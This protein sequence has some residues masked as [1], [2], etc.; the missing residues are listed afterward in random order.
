MTS[1]VGTSST[2]TRKSTLTTCWITGMTRIRPGPLTLSKRPSVKMTPRSYSRRI[3]MV[4]NSR[5]S[6]NTSP[7][8]KKVT[9]RHS[10][11]FSFK[12]AGRP[13]GQKQPFGLQYFNGLAGGNGLVRPGA[14]I[15]ALDINPPFSVCKVINRFREPAVQ[16][17]TAGVN[18][19]SPC[20]CGQIDNG[21]KYQRRGQAHGRNQPGVDAHA[22]HI[23]VNQYDG[24]D[25][26]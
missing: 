23:A 9:F 1:W 20:S 15:L 7:N 6:K 26:H 12:F 13:D 18:G 24:S 10:S 11:F 16:R 17:F 2:T 21:K 8:P 4:L 25:D 14:P 22:R 19:A 5:A 3:F